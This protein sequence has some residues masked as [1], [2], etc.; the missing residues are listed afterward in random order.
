MK[1][2]ILIY[3]FTFILFVPVFSQAKIYY[4]ATNGSDSNAGLT[5]DLPLATIPAAITKAVAGDTIYVRGVVYNLAA[6]ISISKSGTA[7]LPIR[8][9]A[10]PVEKPIIDFSGIGGTSTDGF[11]FSG[12][13]SGILKVLI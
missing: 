1:Q 3:T 11:A 9:W 4:V 8:L 5:I 12:R 2:S 10:Y 7:G 13:S 6:K